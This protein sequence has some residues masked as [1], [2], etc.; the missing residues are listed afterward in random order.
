MNLGAVIQFAAHKILPGRDEGGA[1]K[2]DKLVRLSGGDGL[3]EVV[4]VPPYIRW[5]DGR[6]TGTRNS[7]LGFQ[8]SNFRGFAVGVKAVYRAVAGVGDDY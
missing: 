6:E 4:F 3:R 7:W 8:K 5:K 2:G 1:I